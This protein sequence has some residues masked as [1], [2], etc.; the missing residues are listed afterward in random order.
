MEATDWLI[1]RFDAERRRLVTVAYRMLG[2]VDDAED[3]VQESWIRLTRADHSAVENISGWL[4]TVVSR[5]CLD[6][7]RSRRTRGHQPFEPGYLEPRSEAPPQ[8]DPEQEALLAES[9]GMA[10]LVVLDTLDPAERVAFVLHDMFAVPFEEISAILERSPAAARQLASRARRRVHGA[11]VPS[12]SAR[13]QHELVSA[14][15]AASRRGD[16]KALLGLLDSNILLRADPAALALSA[17]WKD[18]GAPDL[19]SQVCGAESVAATFTGRA[20]GAQPALIGRAAGAAWVSGGQL[21]VIFRFQTDGAKITAIDLI[22]DP[23]TISELE[24]ALLP[25]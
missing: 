12:H 20:A 7:L 8:A 17:Q 13:R 1:E 4:T 2:S 19:A 16:F 10:M 22:A 5:V 24:V 9:I 3:A 15:L 21:K 11:D 14:F 25:S 18:Q 6:Q 23:E